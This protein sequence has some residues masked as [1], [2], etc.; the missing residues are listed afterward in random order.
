MEN[1][2]M[3]WFLCKE[4]QS[5]KYGMLNSPV[6]QTQMVSSGNIN[7]SL[8]LTFS[9]PCPYCTVISLQFTMHFQNK[10]HLKSCF[11]MIFSLKSK[12]VETEKFD[13]EKE[14]YS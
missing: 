4:Y 10:R 9:V 11:K 1:L 14:A 5:D 6:I 8:W 3:E 12:N 2:L 13:N 7:N